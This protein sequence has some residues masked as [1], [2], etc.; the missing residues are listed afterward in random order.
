MFFDLTLNFWGV[1]NGFVLY[2][3]VN[4]LGFDLVKCYGLMNF[5]CVLAWG[6]LRS[7]LQCLLVVF[8]DLCDR[9][10]FGILYYI[11]YL[12]VLLCGILCLEFRFGLGWFA[13]GFAFC[14][15]FLFSDQLVNMM[16]IRS[17]VGVAEVV[18]ALE[19]WCLLGS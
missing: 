6:L 15:C 2:I 19:V 4:V 8:V 12:F 7:L 17:R 18:C 16:D 14:S 11:W 9:R 3:V 1:L 5:G 10:L 13:F